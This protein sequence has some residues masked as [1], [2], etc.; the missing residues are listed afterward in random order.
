MDV[1]DL[2]NF[3]SQQLGVVARRLVGAGIRMRWNDTRGLRLLGI[4]YPTPYLGLFRDEAER[5]LAMMPATQGVIRWP[6]TRPGLAAL[7]EEDE[8]PLTDSAV[9]RMLLIHALEMSSDP[10]ELLR[11]AW[12]VLAAGGRLLAVVPNRRGV[13]ARMDTTP[14]GQGRPYSRSQIIQLLRDA[15]FTPTGWGE[16]LYVPPI[17]RN[18]FLRSAVAWERTGSTLSA[19]F[20]GVHIV[21][22]TKQVYRAIP[23]R[24]EK[25]K[26]VPALQ[27]VLAPSPG[28]AALR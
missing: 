20:A 10:T 12:R 26:L 23:A 7:V 14:F 9:D 28:A 24:R 1:V 6:S 2:R 11:E 4:G 3:Y 17:S 8:L 19:P 16:A 22:A 5:C 25:R 13:W 27:P 18:W 21:E 15:W